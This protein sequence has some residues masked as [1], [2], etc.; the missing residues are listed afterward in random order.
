MFTRN[1]MIEYAWFMYKNIGRYNSS[2]QANEEGLFLD[3]YLKNRTNSINEEATPIFNSLKELKQFMVFCHTHYE[4]N[5]VWH[6][7]DGKKGINFSGPHLNSGGNQKYSP[8]NLPEPP[9]HNKRTDL[10][11]MYGTWLR[12]ENRT[13]INKLFMQEELVSHKVAKLAKEKGFDIPTLYAYDQNGELWFDEMYAINY[14]DSPYSKEVVSAPTQ[15]LLQRW[16]REV[17]NI[18]YYVIPSY[19]NNG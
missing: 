13:V 11:S 16:L 2:K 18:N 12:L 7:E 4:L 3:L 10:E 19:T 8:F 14:N 6:F 1:Q 15:A 5:D 9:D 17:H